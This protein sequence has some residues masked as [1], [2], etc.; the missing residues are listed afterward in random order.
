MLIKML[1]LG[2][3][4]TN[5]GMVEGKDTLLNLQDIDGDNEWGYHTLDYTKS[6]IYLAREVLDLKFEEFDLFEH[7]NVIKEL[8][9]KQ[10]LTLDRLGNPKNDVISVISM[11]NSQ[12]VD[13]EIS[14]EIGNIDLL[15]NA[16]FSYLANVNMSLLYDVSIYYNE[17]DNEYSSDTGDIT[18][19]HQNGVIRFKVDLRTDTFFAGEDAVD[20]IEFTIAL[21]KE[22]IE[23]LLKDKDRN[24]KAKEMITSKL[25]ELS[26]E[27]VLEIPN[28]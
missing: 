27:W 2:N 17:G 22:E 24:L 25:K 8:K 28:E 13:E 11:H 18:I 14:K 4:Q 20:N 16:L 15:G 23:A 9:G 21:E 7:P 1:K 19:E 3:V 10:L 5:V 26:E 6:P 12:S